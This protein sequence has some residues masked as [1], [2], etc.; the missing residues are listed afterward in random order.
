MTAKPVLHDIQLDISAVCSD[1]GTYLF[2]NI[3]AVDEEMPKS[4]QVRL[5][6]VF[7]RHLSEKHKNGT[8]PRKISQLHQVSGCVGD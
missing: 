2:S 3:R 5:D 6:D 8:K 1:C 4:G 7:K